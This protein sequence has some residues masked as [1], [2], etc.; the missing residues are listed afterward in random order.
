MDRTGVDSMI[1]HS[2]MKCIISNS[3][4]GSEDATLF[5]DNEGVMEDN[6]NNLK[7][8]AGNQ[9]GE[10]GDYSK[11]RVADYSQNERCDN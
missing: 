7:D 1:E 2:F 6:T 10:D 3:L 11:V 5:I 8:V 9:S 4:D